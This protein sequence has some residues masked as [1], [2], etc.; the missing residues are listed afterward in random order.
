MEIM[1]D[2]M[3]FNFTLAVEKDEA[4]CKKIAKEVLKIFMNGFGIDEFG[5]VTKEDMMN[6]FFDMEYEFDYLIPMYGARE[7]ITEECAQKIVKAYPNVYFDIYYRC[8]DDYDTVYE[9]TISYYGDKLNFD[10]DVSGGDE[11]FDD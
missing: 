9:T 7:D 2:V 11:D 3:R 8:M 6:N 1:E 5:D 10:Y 4:E